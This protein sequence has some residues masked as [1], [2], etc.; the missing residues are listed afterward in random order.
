[1]VTAMCKRARSLGALV[2]L[3]ALSFGAPAGA[4]QAVKGSGMLSKKH[5]AAKLLSVEE[6][7][8]QVTPDTMILN[9]EGHRIGFAAIPSPAENEVTVEYE[10]T[11]AAGRVRA[12]RLVVWIEPE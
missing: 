7:Q 5:A 10:G 4:Q 1:M 11:L 12:E 2:L 6:V 9:D 8:I 3:A